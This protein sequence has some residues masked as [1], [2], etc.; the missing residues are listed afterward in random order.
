MPTLRKLVLT[1]MLVAV[2]LCGTSLAQRF[3]LEQTAERMSARMDTLIKQLE[4][5]AEQEEPVRAVL[6]ELVR[7][8]LQLRQG[9]AQQGS[10]RERMQALND[11]TTARLETLLTEEQL[12]RYKELSANNRRGRRRF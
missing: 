12:D 6:A 4:L 10:M 5:T 7:G 1:A 11:S 2:P 3:N 9:G 8:R